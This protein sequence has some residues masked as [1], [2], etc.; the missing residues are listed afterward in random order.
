MR[1]AALAALLL[2]GACDRGAPPASLEVTHAPT[3]AVQRPNFLVLLPDSLRA[4][5]IEAERDGAPVAPRM[6]G[7]AARGAVF[8]EAVSQAGWTMPALA[9][10]LTGRHPVLPTADASMLGWIG[11]DHRTFPEILALYGYRTHG[12]L[13]GNAAV[14]EQSFAAVEGDDGDPVAWLASAP[15]EPFL[16]IVHDVDLQFVAG[17]DALEGQAGARARCERVVANRADRSRISIGELQQCLDP[18]GRG[19][20]TKPRIQ[21]A[22]D[23]AVGSWDARLGAMLDALEASGQADRTVVIL[24]SPHGHHLGEGGRWIHGTLHQPDL[25]IPLVWADPD[26]ANPGGHIPTTVQ[27]LDL[28][29]SIL[30]RAGA[31]PEAGMTGQSLLPLLGLAAGRYEPGDIYSVNDQRN[32]ALRAGDLS[33]IRFEPGGPPGSVREPGWLLFDLARDPE[34]HRELM[35]SPHPP[36]EAA[37]MQARLG[38]FHQALLAE[39]ARGLPPAGAEPDEALRQHLRDHGYWHHVAPDE[40]APP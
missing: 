28:A 22:Y 2:A 36:P 15:Q 40:G 31:V 1:R 8:D 7:L 14:L 37:A 24:A 27:L 38:A 4:D 21:A 19:Q 25:H 17:W 9:T 5:R 30:A 20:D 3:L 13:G 12:F 39:S 6:A 34:E 33:L 16:A 11:Q 10:A 35:K 18:D 26:L 32:V 29:P 23:R